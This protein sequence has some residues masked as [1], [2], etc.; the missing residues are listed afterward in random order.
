MYSTNTGYSNT[1]TGN[2]ELYSNTSGYDNTA[3][4]FSALS[5]NTTGHDNTAVGSGADVTSN[6]LSNATA[7]GANASVNASNKVR[8]GDI[9]VLVIEG[10]VAWTSSSDS[11]KKEN[12]LPS[13]GE[14]ILDKISGLWLGSWNF[15]GHEP[16][17]F[18]H[19]GP[20]AQAF[21]RAFGN[22]GIGTVGTETTICASD[23]DGINMIAVQ[24]LEKRTTELKEEVLALKE[25]NKMLRELVYEKLGIR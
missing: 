19:Y 18:R 14:E 21:Y 11:T 22:D 23:I 2:S 13:D 4:G 20:M 12:F 5:T 6:N 24:A 25:E 10:E 8:I 1:A 3:V 17:R 7:I 16:E 9:H 15:Q